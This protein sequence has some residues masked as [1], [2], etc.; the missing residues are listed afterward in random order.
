LVNALYHRLKS[1]LP[2]TV[3][4]AIK[5]QLAE[6]YTFDYPAHSYQAAPYIDREVWHLQRTRFKLPINKF[7]RRFN[8]TPPISFEEGLRRTI[9]WLAH[10]GVVSYEPSWL[11]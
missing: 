1:R 5:S 8:Y 4:S 2:D 9:N 6:P 7:A 10:I 11:A 3:K